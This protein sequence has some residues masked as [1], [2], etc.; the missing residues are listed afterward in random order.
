[1]RFQLDNWNKLKNVCSKEIGGKMKRKEPVGEDASLTQ[2]ITDKL[3]SLT[4]E[5]LRVSI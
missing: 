1:M 3:D 5:N 4:T 2:E